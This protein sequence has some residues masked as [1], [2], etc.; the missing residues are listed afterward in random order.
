MQELQIKKQL[1]DLVIDR[2]KKKLELLKRGKDQAQADANEHVGAMESRYD[3][4]KE[5]AQTLVNG[6]AMQIQKTSNVL[7]SI[8]QLPLKIH[9]AIEIGT[10]ILTG[11]GAFFVSTGLIEEPLEVDGAKYECVNLGAPIVQ[12]I[13]KA[14][15]SV[16]EVGGRKIKV[17]KIF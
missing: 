7:A 14:R 2:L 8:Q 11:G 15:S 3:T 16:A 13:Q 12:K 6:F 9:T 5:E 17:S 4:F 1:V 10:V